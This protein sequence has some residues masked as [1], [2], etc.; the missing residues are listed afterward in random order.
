MSERRK[1]VVL[2][3][4]EVA[5]RLEVTL[6]DYRTRYYKEIPVASRKK[7]CK[8]IEK[9]VVE[10]EALNFYNRNAEYLFY[11]EAMEA[12]NKYNTTNIYNYLESV[13]KEVLQYYNEDFAVSISDL[14][15]SLK[16]KLIKS[17][18]KIE[19]EFRDLSKKLSVSKCISTYYE[20]YPD[21]L[22]LIELVNIIDDI[23]SIGRGT[24]APKIPELYGTKTLLLELEEKIKIIESI[25]NT[26]C[27]NV[28][29]EYI[30]Y[31]IDW[32]RFQ[33]IK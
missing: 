18:Y 8:W 11:E 2:E 10:T 7:I 6:S 1:K 4:N 23:Y 31:L 13:V 33:E 20:K 3:I 28:V 21:L 26:A 19:N 25:E 27:I 24:S 30:N 29:L 5:E 17:G 22:S 12:E 15:D 32:N 14:I 16:N 9:A